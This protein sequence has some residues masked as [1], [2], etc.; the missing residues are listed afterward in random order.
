MNQAKLTVGML[1]LVGLGGAGFGVREYQAA[2][3]AEEAQA[4]AIRQ[5]A[6]IRDR[7]GRLETKLLT[8]TRQADAVERDNAAL[9]ALRERFDQARR[10]VLGNPDDL[11]PLGMMSSI[12]RALGDDQALVAVYDAIPPGDDRRKSVAI[13]AQ[14][15]LIAARR[16][17]DALF[18]RP[19]SSMSSSFEL[20]TQYFVAPKAVGVPEQS[21]PR[22]KAHVVTSTATNIEI[23]AGAGDLAH[24][25][26]LAARLLAVDNSQATRDLLQQHLERAGQPGLLAAPKP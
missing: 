13:Y 11:Q 24:A 16:Y 19:Y 5:S 14:P 2:S 15:G 6:S 3:A 17:N 23:L 1:V 21:A 18:G 26:E 10:R 4:L 8:E 20:Q 7:I 12:A 9:A 22:L 25:R